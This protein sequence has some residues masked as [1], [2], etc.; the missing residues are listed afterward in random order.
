MNWKGEEIVICDALRTPFSHGN[1]LKNNSPVQLL[2]TV[3]RELLKRNS[4][5]GS[6]VSGVIAGTVLQDSRYP[7]VARQAA[8]EADVAEQSSDYT[9]QANCNSAFTGLLSALGNILSGLGDLYICSGVEVMSSYGLGIRD[10]TGEY[11]PLS[12]ARELLENDLKSFQNTYSLVDCLEE[13]LTDRS[14]NVS[15]IE[16]GEIMANLYQISREEQDG[17]TFENLKKAIEAVEGKKLSPHIVPLDDLNEDSY[18]INRKRMLRKP[19]LFKRTPLI[20]DDIESFRK[21][22]QKHLSSLGM[23]KLNPT[24][25]MYTSSIPGDGAGACILTTESN[26]RS[27]GL[28]PRFRL[29]GW[30]VTGVNPVI[31]GIGPNEAVEKLFTN[32]KTKRAEGITMDHIDQIELHEAFASQVL[33]VLKESER[34]YSRIWKREKMNPYGGSLAFT[35]PLGATNYRLLTNAFSRFEE[36]KTM[37][38]AL[39]AGCAGG[40]QGTALLISRYQ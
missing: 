26:A 16:I 29:I 13:C 1:K 15:M 19:E 23:E 20:F 8:M 40:G 22:H 38:Y 36:D 6:H 33:S 31:M 27:L 24:V 37:G 3:I 12:D 2:S 9:V 5:K 4:L 7:N 18:P 35:H 30:A 28:E 10:R 11:G 21:K 14:N 25:T 17:Y 32:P 39:L 34:K